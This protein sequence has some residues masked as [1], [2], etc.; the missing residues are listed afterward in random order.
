MI[1]WLRRWTEQSRTP[2][3]QAVPWPSATTCTS[4]CRAPESMVS[5]NITPLPKARERLVP[6]LVERG[7]EL[8]RRAHH[9]DAATAAAGGGLEHQRVAERLGLGQR[10]AQ[11]LD[12]PLAPRRDRHAD[13]LGQ[14]LGTDLVAQGPHRRRARADEGDA[15]PLA[16][17]GE[18]RVL[19]DEA[20]A[21]PGGVGTGVDQRPFEHRVVQVRPG[22]GRTQRV[23]QVGLPDEL[24]RALAVGVEGHRLD[25]LAGGVELADGVDEAH[26]GLTT[27]DDG[28]AP[29]HRCP[30]ARGPICQCGRHNPNGSGHPRRLARVQPATRRNFLS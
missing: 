5:R 27:V 11:V 7:G 10:R 25:L 4:T 24:G 23:A 26:R 15:Q 14:Q 29:E 1:F 19:G 3:A 12:R 6:G 17:L 9:P 18:V 2:I 21:H 20:P 28:N 8:L 22:R 16:Q 13:L 30:P